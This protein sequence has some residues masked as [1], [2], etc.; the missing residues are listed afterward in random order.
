MD[1]IMAKKRWTAGDTRKIVVSY[2]AFLE[3]G[4]MIVTATV[5]SDAG[6]ISGIST[7]ESARKV[8]FFLAGGIANT[9]L[10][11][12]VQITDSFGQVVTDTIEYAVEAP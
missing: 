6:S 11:V 8:Q 12:T 3:T 4:A 1:M 9:V 7:I 2:D 5:T 10:T